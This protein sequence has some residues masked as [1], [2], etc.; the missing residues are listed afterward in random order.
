MVMR[1]IRDYDHTVRIDGYPADIV[2]STE[3]DARSAI[4][5][6]R[7]YAAREMEQERRYRKAAEQANGGR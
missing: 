6:A 4:A 2:F 7:E 5:L 3:A 1:P